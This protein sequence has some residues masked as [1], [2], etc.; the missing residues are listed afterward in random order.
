MID[1][2]DTDSS[3][4]AP[5]RRIGSPCVL[6]KVSSPPPPPPPPRLPPPPL[7]PPLPLPPPPL[8]PPPPSPPPSHRE[9]RKG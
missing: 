1:N 7:P 9:R 2:S 6:E 3:S 8:P 5:V 4:G